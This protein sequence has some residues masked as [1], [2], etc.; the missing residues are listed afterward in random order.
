[1][2][3][4]HGLHSASQPENAGHFGVFYSFEPEQTTLYKRRD[5]S[6]KS[7]GSLEAKI[8][9]A[10]EIL[11]RVH[12]SHSCPSQSVKRDKSSRAVRRGLPQ[13]MGSVENELWNYL[14]SA[15]GP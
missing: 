7:R 9:V 4:L 3:A 15:E 12:F 13:G 1:M 10:K 11:H 5:I 14:P 6:D 2:G 8:L